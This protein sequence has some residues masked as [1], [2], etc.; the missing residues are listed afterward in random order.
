MAMRSDMPSEVREFA[1]TLVVQGER[2]AALIRKVLDF[3]RRTVSE[4]RTVELGSFLQ[5]CL[6]FL[7]RLLPETVR[8]EVDISP[9]SHYVRADVVQMQQVI[10]NLIVNARDA[11]PEGSDA[12]RFAKD[13]PGRRL[14]ATAPFNGA[15]GMGVNDGFR[16]RGWHRS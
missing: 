15:W 10:A 9:G 11:M 4:Q 5:E 8:S 1:K 7:S 3:S 14:S 16:Y 13:C 2:S 6:Q 12:D